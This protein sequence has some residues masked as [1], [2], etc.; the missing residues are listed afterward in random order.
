MRT[1]GSKSGSVWAEKKNGKDTGRYRGRFVLPNGVVRN[2]QGASKQ[3]VREQI[4]ELKREIKSGMHGSL[5]GRQAFLDFAKEYRAGEKHL[6]P[7]TMRRYDS[8][9]RNYF[10]GIGHILLEDLKPQQIQR[11]Y[12]KLL[13]GRSSSTVHLLHGFFHVVLERAVKL[14]IIPRNPCDNVD[15]P[16]LKV[17][18]F[19]ALT[20]E[21]AMTL[22]AYVQQTNDR[23]AALYILTLFSGMRVSE[24]L[25]LTWDSIDY[26]NNIIR[27]AKQL[28]KMEDGSYQLSILKTRTSRR[29][30]P[31][32]PTVVLALDTWRDIQEG[33]KRKVGSAWN[34]KL[35]VLFTNE[36]GWHLTQAYVNKAFH[37]MLS[38]AHLPDIR[39]HDLR[40]TFATL[41][42]E[43]GVPIKV[44]SELLGHANVAITLKTY[45]H[46]TDRMRGSAGQK[47]AQLYTIEP[48]SERLIE[49]QKID[50][51]DKTP[52][53]PHGKERG[54]TGEARPVVTV[55]A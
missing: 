3:E 32:V 46:V 25:G 6:E 30:L 7:A 16:P 13:D 55:R 17:E 5:A 4:F 35:N 18:E 21:Q 23:L 22:I 27:V 8:Y 37:K 29:E 54:T 40:H 38:D 12:A 28:K 48:S 52:G 26:R 14:D 11:H 34:N 44:V 41:L 31:L 50:E 19:Q 47:I 51:N 42:I 9:L 36:I 45:A 15:A 2:L 39:F 20:E 33:E 24:V 53:Y 10:D 49:A 1:T 43:K